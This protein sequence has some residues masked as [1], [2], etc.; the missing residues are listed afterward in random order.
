MQ[1]L[2]YSQQ[3]ADGNISEH[4]ES[5]E[6]TLD[7]PLR[8]NTLVAF[9]LHSSASAEVDNSAFTALQKIMSCNQ[10]D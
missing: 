8:M 3:Q 9:F 5:K 10:K 2:L 4:N 1:R 7:V 6:H